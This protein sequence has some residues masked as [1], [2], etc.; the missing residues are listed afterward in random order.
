MLLER[1]VQVRDIC[2]VV[3]PVMDFHRPRV[4]VR[5]ERCEVIRELGKFMRHASSSSV[6]R[7]IE[8]YITSSQHPTP[9]SQMTFAF[10]ALGVRW[11]LES[12]VEE[13]VRWELS[14]RID[15]MR[16]RATRVQRF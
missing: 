16:S 3:L 10:D 12:E 2:L 6:G 13:V 11:R 14:Y 4:D 9:N 7:K 15:N 8:S 1:C 5:L